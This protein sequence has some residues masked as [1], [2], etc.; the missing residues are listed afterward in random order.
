MDRDEGTFESDDFI[1]RAVIFL[2]DVNFSTDNRV[3]VPNWFPVGMGFG[4]EDS[5][6]QGE[7]LVSF[8]IV[9]CDYPY[10]LLPERV[11][12]KPETEDFLIEINVLGLRDL[13]SAGLVP[14]KKPFVKFNLKSLLP[15][16]LGGSVT[17]IKT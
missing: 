11:A 7:I 17:N 16:S 6:M 3:P 10:A 4:E 1:G 9:E 12:L 8:S 13:E 5:T 2:K 15:P 14:V